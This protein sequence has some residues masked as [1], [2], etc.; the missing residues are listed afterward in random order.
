MFTT[1]APSALT[2]PSANTKLWVASTTASTR[3]L[4]HGPSRTRRERG[5]EEVPARP[6]GDGEVEHLG[7]EHERAGHAEQRDDAVVEPAAGAT[8]ADADGARGDDRGA[9]GD[10]GRQE[11]VRDVHGAAPFAVHSGQSPTIGKWEKSLV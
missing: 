10:L 6:P 7:G 5:A 4:S 11:P 3:Q 9:G 1:F 2:P 8:E